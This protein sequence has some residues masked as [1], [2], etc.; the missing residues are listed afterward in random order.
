M[1]R[2]LPLALLLA[3]GGPA[4]AADNHTTATVF[5]PGV[6]ST[7]ADEGAVGFMPDGATVYFSRGGGDHYAIVYSQRTGNTWSAAK[8]A[9]F[10]GHWL[11]T[12]DSMSP[13]GSFMVFASNRP[14][15]G[16][17]AVL[18]MTMGGK[19]YPGHGL[20]LW[21][22][23]RSGNGWGEPERLP[24][25][26]N[27]C[28][29]VFAPDVGADGTL[30]YI[31]CGADGGLRLLRSVQ[32]DGHYQTPE[33]VA[34]GEDGLIVRDPAI[35]HDGSF[36][37]ASIKKGKTQ[38][39]R[40]A[41]AFATPQ[42]WSAPQDLGDTVNGG[43]HA[44]AAQLGPDGRT[45][46]Y[47]SDRRV[48]GEQADWNKDG[49]NLWQVS[50]APWLDAH[51][52]IGAPVAGPWDHLR[53][54]SP[55]F[56]PGDRSVVF[57]RSVDD[58]SR[59]FFSSRNGDGWT[60][61]QPLPFST[62]WE[63]IEP[64]MATDGSSLIFSS[65]R[66][67]QEG[68]AVLDGVYDGKRYPGHGGNLWQVARTKDGWG[69]P[70]RLSTLLNTNT[71]VFS[72]ALAA[73]GTLYFMRTDPDANGKGAFRLF[74]SRLVQGQ[75]QAPQPLPFSDGVTGDFDPAVAPDQSFV[76]FSSKRAPAGVAGSELFIAF[77][78]GA[79]WSAPQPLGLTG[80]EAR[81][82]TDHATLYFNAPD[83]R[84]HAFDLRSWLAR[85]GAVAD[86]ARAH[87]P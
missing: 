68:G 79:G 26:I 50:L 15:D 82:S 17:G 36:M 32:K 6:I 43:T 58:T 72:P 7:A 48:P 53:D 65:N 85:H 77:A 13:D 84:V 34:F 30:Y 16:K 46:Y 19:N 62:Q 1:R 66:P 14:A 51:A 86:V 63:D 76:V 38:P 78:Q 29:S 33:P 74:R 64:A 83:R 5:G 75:Y 8:T 69:Q 31:G 67:V 56:G 11:D 41:I 59:L 54:I 3:L 52:R 81:L 22:V 73:D 47:A 27:N 12:D 70:Q 9:P 61:A 4:A 24:A 20:N 71:A 18:D 37:V 35:A 60:A 10:S 87:N 39:Y 55:A 40:L 28:N 42:G 49:D 80:I 45:L 25:T 2:L 23:A 21:R 57:T 44:M